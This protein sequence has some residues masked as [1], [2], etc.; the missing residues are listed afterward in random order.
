M[1]QH[2]PSSAN[3]YSVDDS[4]P[5]LL[6]DVRERDDYDACHIIRGNVLSFSIYILCF[7]IVF[8]WLRFDAM[9]SGSNTV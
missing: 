8:L 9:L 4:C 1:N 5:Y 2:A 6:L 3:V 7:K